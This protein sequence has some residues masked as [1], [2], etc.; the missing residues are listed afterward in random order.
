MN[1]FNLPDLGEGLPDA[2]IVEWFVKE[3]DVVQLDAPLVAMETA[4]A[5]V[6]VPSPATGTIKKL[7]GKPGDI[8]KTGDV[9]VEYV[10][11]INSKSNKRPDTGTVAGTLIIGDT[12]ITDRA[13][14][15]RS[16][17]GA[18]ATPAVR[19]L[20]QRMQVDLNQVTPTG[21][22]NTITSND[23]EQAA[24]HLSQA[25]DLELFKGVRR[26]MAQTMEKNNLEL[27]PVTLVDDAIF[28][29]FTSKTDISIAIMQALVKACNLEPALNA[30]FDGKALGRRLIKQ[31]DLGIAIDTEDGLFVPVLRDVGSKDAA[32]LRTELNDLKQQ[33][34]QRTLKPEDMR[35]ASFILSNFGKF[36]GRYASPIIV[37]PS[38]AILAVGKIRDVIVPLDG[39]A[40]VAKALPLSLSFDHRACTGGEASRFLG[41]VLDSLQS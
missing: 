23:I 37:P 17:S 22:N 12:V 28:H 7:C 2:E 14:N 11:D 4:K 19:A 10:E 5:V 1:K 20:A 39:K 41:A 21:P 26:S 33:T 6:D 35:G 34:M 32:T 29:N 40:V 27:V 13:T 8:I 30:W 18:K 31:L 25:G 36:A 16:Q 9:L 38:V 3:G 24:T 15:V